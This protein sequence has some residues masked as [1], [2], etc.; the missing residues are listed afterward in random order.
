MSGGVLEVYDSVEFEGNVALAGRG[1]GV[2][3]DVD[4]LSI[5]V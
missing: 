3:S 1:G 2:R 5:L 4:G